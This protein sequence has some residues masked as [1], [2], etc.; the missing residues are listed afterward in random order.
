MALFGP[1]TDPAAQARAKAE[2]QAWVAPYPSPAAFFDEA[3]AGPAA[4]LLGR[5]FEQT[6]PGAATD[7]G[8]GGRDREAVVADMHAALE[9]YTG[10]VGAVE[11]LISLA[12]AHAAAAPAPAAASAPVP[13]L[14]PF[15]A[16]AGADPLW[17]STH[18]VAILDR[19]VAADLIPAL[20]LYA[21]RF[22]S[23][24]AAR[25]SAGLG[26]G[27]TT[28]ATGGVTEPSSLSIGSRLLL[29]VAKFCQHVCSTLAGTSRELDVRT[30]LATAA[31]AAAPAPAP[32]GGAGAA[33]SALD[34]SIAL[35]RVAEGL[36]W[37]G[38]T[39]TLMMYTGE[40]APPPARGPRATRAAAAF[41]QYFPAAA[42]TA[43]GAEAGGGWAIGA[44]PPRPSV[45]ASVLASRW[46]AHMSQLFEPVLAEYVGDD[47]RGSHRLPLG[48][49]C[50]ALADHLV[51]RALR[52]AGPAD[53]PSTSPSSGSGS[54]SG[55]PR[56]GA[57]AGA[58]ASTRS[59]QYFVAL[60]RLHRAYVHED[61][62]ANDRAQ[63]QAQLAASGAVLHMFPAVTTRPPG[64]PRGA[65]GVAKGA[66]V[67][68]AVPDVAT[69]QRLQVTTTPCF[70]ISTSSFL[71]SMCTCR[72]P[73]PLPPSTG[74]ARRPGR[75][76]AAVVSAHVRALLEGAAVPRRLQD[77]RGLPAGAPLS[78][79]I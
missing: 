41:A 13:A 2:A 68:P 8:G 1:S 79:P 36:Y 27:A 75:G 6:R 45:G 33:G 20:A 71:T 16:A 61:G 18:A 14:G 74:V 64:A 40:E 67:A 72:S 52:G 56:A 30:I 9:G 47:G 58:G 53:R 15:L 55:S 51:D 4:R 5:L 59:G 24:D 46:S 32:A 62:A 26:H 34:R 77:P 63:T 50:L 10:L 54:G 31:A 78:I 19:A 42:G 76:A 37:A 23:T 3:L 11:D 22:L 29:R 35:R 7:G 65:D 60:V 12:A 39:A 49:E 66:Y 70:V 28:A 38:L 17:V 57:G 44:P 48:T 21:L 69:W 25:R 43:S 73:S